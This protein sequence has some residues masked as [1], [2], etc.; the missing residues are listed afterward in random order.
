MDKEV[1]K[2]KCEPCNFETIVK[3]NIDR[4]YTTRKHLD[5]VNPRP[6]IDIAPSTVNAEYTV[7][8]Y[9]ILDMSLAKEFL[10]AIGDNVVLVNNA[11]YIYEGRLWVCDNTKRKLQLLIVNTLLPVFQKWYVKETQILRGK[12]KIT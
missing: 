5:K 10:K 3:C 7:L 1:K 12:K 11:P 8:E 4:H 2:Y 6:V 9:S